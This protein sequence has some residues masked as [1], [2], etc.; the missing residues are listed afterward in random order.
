MRPTG[1]S[2]RATGNGLHFPTT[3]FNLATAAL[4]TLTAGAAS[5]FLPGTQVRWKCWKFHIRRTSPWRGSRGLCSRIWS[6]TCGTCRLLIGMSVSHVDWPLSD[7]EQDSSLDTSCMSEWRACW[8]TGAQSP[9]MLTADIGKLGDSILAPVRS[10]CG[11][12]S[13]IYEFQ[14]LSRCGAVAGGAD[15]GHRQAGRQRAAEDACT[16]PRAPHSGRRP[17][18]P[19]DCPPCGQLVTAPGQQG[20]AHLQAA[21]ND[22]SQHGPVLMLAVYLCI[23]ACSQWI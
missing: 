5:Q 9:A 22:P 2:P 20:I 13:C 16:A 17:V 23:A 18:F 15:S 19:G 21:Q 12:T 11:H 3:G 8:G 7:D 10:S 1:A 4:G 14:S 6:N